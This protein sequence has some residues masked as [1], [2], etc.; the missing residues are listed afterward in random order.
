MNQSS[1]RILDELAKL[2]TDSVGLSQGLK[3][4]IE[5]IMC[6]QTEWFVRKMD[7]INRE[8]FDALKQM[9]MKAREENDALHEQINVLEKRIYA[10]EKA[11]KNTTKRRLASRP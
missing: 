11:K 4:E 2:M 7:L 3:R 6:T 10:L 9:S 8:E 1:N 5:T